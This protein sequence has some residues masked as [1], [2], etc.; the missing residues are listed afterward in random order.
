MS[1]S[2]DE[3]NEYIRQQAREAKRQ[4]GVGDYPDIP[5]LLDARRGATVRINVPLA[6]LHAYRSALHDI[7]REIAS[8]LEDSLPQNMKGRHVGIVLGMYAETWHRYAALWKKR[9]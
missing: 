4:A 9:T 7:Q 8:Q 3:V 6:S 5:P 2:A 1:M